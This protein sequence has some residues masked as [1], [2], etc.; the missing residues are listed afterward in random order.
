[1]YTQPLARQPASQPCRYF[2]LWLDL[3]LT[4][5]DDDGDD[6]D[7]G[8]GGSQQARY[9]GIT[10]AAVVVVAVVVGTFPPNTAVKASSINCN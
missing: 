4:E 2:L 8:D 10:A 5:A 7:D 9:S 6:G 1:M 3:M